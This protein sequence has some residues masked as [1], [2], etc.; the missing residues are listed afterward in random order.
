MS[1]K[2]DSS[3][4]QAGELLHTKH[5]FPPN[6]LGYCGPDVRG[7]ILDYLH[8]HS[9]GESLLPVL[10]KFEAAYP[11]V[12]MIAKSTGKSPF[13]YKVTEAYWLGNSLLNRVEPVEFYEFAH[14]DL[15]PSRK[16]VG[17]KDGLRKE[18]AKS[19]FRELGFNA[20]PHHTFYVLGMY[21]RSSD[22][23]GTEEKLLELMD[24]CR[25]SWG[26]VSEVK[27]ETLVVERPSLTLT[28]DRISL[29]RPNKKEITY[30]PEIHPFSNIHI[31]DWV[32]IHWNF[33]SE[34]LLPYQLK[35]L[36]Q[37]TALDIEATNRLVA[38]QSRGK[39]SGGE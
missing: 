35:N 26:R 23:S 13:D 11:F 3:K 36:K 27:R 7:R 15:A 12:R 38:S 29:T 6:S 34:K 24:S 2:K 30:D 14:Q 22:K 20:K 39:G 17:K 37:F 10:T 9:D 8:N 21:A 4:K 31:G 32:S 28:R 1:L 5:A 19:L 18:E 25:I 16:T 33:A